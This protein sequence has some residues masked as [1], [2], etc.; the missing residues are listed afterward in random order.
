MDTTKIS[1]PINIIRLEGEIDGI[2]KVIYLFM[3]LQK[4]LEKQTKCDGK[5]LMVNEY[6]QKS[7]TDLN[8]QKRK[9]DFF[10][11]IDPSLK[12]VNISNIEDRYLNM[13]TKLFKKWSSTKNIK[14]VRFHYLDVRDR[15]N[16]LSRYVSDIYY[17]WKK[18]SYKDFDVKKVYHTIN[19]LQLLNNELTF[20]V[21][22]LKQ[23]T[24]TSTSPP[25]KK[26]KKPKLFEKLPDY[27]KLLKN[28]KKV[29]IE[30]REKSEYV[31]KKMFTKYNHSNVQKKLTKL[32]TD[33]IIPFGDYLIFT[34]DNAYKT[35]I[36]EIE[37]KFNNA[38]TNEEKRNALNE[39]YNK[40]YWLIDA[41]TFYMAFVFDIYF[42][43]RFL[44]KDYITNV[45]AYTLTMHAFNLIFILVDIFDFKIT[46][47]SYAVTKDMDELNKL[48]KQNPDYYSAGMFLPDKSYG[49]KLFLSNG[50]DT[51]QCSDISTFPPNFT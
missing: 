7:L 46:H 38:V 21:D 50:Y 40:T 27:G 25:N 34:L 41:V 23:Y 19:C 22:L 15:V 12:T 1:G 11:A 51:I 29:M 30:I 20:I 6:F 28:S 31:I 8:K 43:R 32:M 48:V 18:D 17:F 9:S 39:I 49:F 3:D 26:L 37:T 4:T 36:N 47:A 16:Y 2:K 10:M 33:N 35:A 14:N 5:S 44:D 42:L 24:S 13:L 45:I